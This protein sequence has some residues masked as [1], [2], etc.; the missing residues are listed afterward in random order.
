MPMARLE[1]P[2]RLLEIQALPAGLVCDVLA[3][4]YESESAARLE[5]G[6]G[7]TYR[8]LA[9]ADQHDTNVASRDLVLDVLRKR[10]KNTE[11]DEH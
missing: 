5:I 3:F 2:A 1:S 10:K 6:W 11:A 9:D 7:F 4:C 8:V